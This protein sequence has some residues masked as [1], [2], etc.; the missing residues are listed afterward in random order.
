MAS[1]PLIADDEPDTEDTARRRLDPELRVM[2][3]MIRQLEELPEKARY[4]VIAW[5]SHRYMEH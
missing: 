2:G 1:E 4:R 5:L 3:S